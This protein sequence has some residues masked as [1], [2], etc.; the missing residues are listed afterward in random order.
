MPPSVVIVLGAV[1]YMS[2]WWK[3]GMMS[4]CFRR[5]GG[6]RAMQRNDP[7]VRAAFSQKLLETF[8]REH[9]RKPLDLFFTYLMD[10][11]VEPGVIDEIRK[12]GVPT[13]NFSC[14]NAHQFDL[15]DEISTHFDFNLHSEKDARTKFLEIGATPLW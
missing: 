14:N 8:C 5:R 13:C 4:Y 9:T 6:R 2:H 3:W 15:V 11:M 1:T 10:G 7:R 12:T